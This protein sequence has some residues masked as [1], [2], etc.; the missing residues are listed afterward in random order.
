MSHSF[1]HISV[2]TAEVIGAIESAD[3]LPHE[4]FPLRISGW[5]LP[6]DSTQTGGLSI[7]AKVGEDQIGISQPVS[8]KDVGRSYPKSANAYYAGFDLRIP[9][10]APGA[11]IIIEAESSQGDH[12][13][14]GRIP[15]GSIPGRQPCHGNYPLWSAQNHL[16][17]TPCFSRSV[18]SELRFSVIIPVFNPPVESFLACLESLEKQSYAAWEV[19][20]VDDGS[21]HLDIVTLLRELPQ[22]DPRITVSIQSRNQGIAKTLN[23]AVQHARYEWLVFLDHDDVLLPNALSEMAACLIA[24][25]ETDVAYSDE[26]KITANGQPWLPFLKPGYSPVFLRGVMYPGHLLCVRR[27]L[28]ISVGGFDSNFDGIQDYEFVL[29]ISEVSDQFLHLPKI[30]YQWRMIATSSAA[31]GN[32]KGDMDT[33]QARAVDAHL[34]RLKVPAKASAISGHRILVEPHEDFAAP[35]YSLASYDCLSSPSAAPKQVDEYRIF[36]SDFASPPSPDQINALLLL[37]ALSPTHVIVPTLL[38]LDGLVYESGCTLGTDGSIISIMR[39]FDPQGDGYNG[40]LRCHREALTSGGHVAVISSLLWERLQPQLGSSFDP[41]RFAQS[42]V[43]LHIPVVVSAA[44]KCSLNRN[45]T[46]LPALSPIAW[47]KPAP[48]DPYWNPAF[49]SDSADY[50]LSLIEDSR[51]FFHL[52]SPIL[53]GSLDGR[54]AV[55]GWTHLVGEDA[56]NVRL[57]I[58]DRI[59]TANFGESRPDVVESNPMFSNAACGF[60]SKF[61][62]PAGTHLVEIQISQPNDSDW[63]TVARQSVEVPEASPMRPLPASL[64]DSTLL[65]FQFGIHSKHP[66]KPVNFPQLNTAS[67]KSTWPALSIVTPN[68]N[69][70]R[71]LADVIQSVRSSTSHG[72]THFVQDGGSSD[73]SMS[74]LQRLESA[75]LAWVSES[76]DGQSDAINRGFGRCSGEASDV[77]AWINADDFYVPGALDR[78]RTYFAEHPEVD[79]IYGNR[80][81]VDEAGLEINR[82]TVPGH[83]H[84]VLK[85]NDF[86]PQETMFWRR[87]LWTKLG[88]LDPQFQF[89]MDWDFLLR[90]QETGANIVHLP[91]FLGCFR[92]HPTQKTSAQIQSVGQREIDELRERTF[93]KRINPA[94]LLESPAIR[95]FL[96]KSFELEKPGIANWKPNPDFR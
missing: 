8:R 55:S 59:I 29:R 48:E 17:E 30:L 94:D 76:D 68:L 23:A 34:K 57:R 70:G 95:K 6:R 41:A 64:V 2:D 50:R 65:A 58:D 63:L 15:V 42:L 87:R 9:S 21:T 14:V 7:R 36:Y 89:A 44:V 79:L 84:D 26:E 51:L 49:D 16:L 52:D 12:W 61:E 78:I 77:M 86:I 28:A 37:S 54:I 39:G 27:E 46:D 25:P 35:S 93:G 92:I 22:R 80:I 96:R 11:L 20:V 90:A 67:I 33:L 3:W 69:Q 38:S 74:E 53:H 47:N 88:G 62:L 82:W 75:E 71:F 31:S 56:P 81:V 32:I 45:L 91:E 85:L 83:D 10:V 43:Q 72:I 40:S 13:I 4:V 60:S 24:R 18:T 1:D 5:V 73:N 66:P 19:L